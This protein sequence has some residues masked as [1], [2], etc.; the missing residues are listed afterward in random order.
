MTVVTDY[1]L[2]PEKYPRE[3]IY[4]G[5]GWPQDN[6]P[7]VLKEAIMKVLNDKEKFTVSVRYG[8]TRGI[9]EFIDAIANYEEKIIGRKISKD[10]IIVGLGSTDLT[11]ALLKVILDEGDEIIITS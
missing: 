10:Q 8:A 7:A 5:G 2:H 9:P 3:L 11:S 4:L 6:P 1:K